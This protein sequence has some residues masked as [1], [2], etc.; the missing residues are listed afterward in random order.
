MCFDGFFFEIRKIKCYFAWLIN[1]SLIIRSMSVK[2]IRKALVFLIIML[3]VI[4]DLGCKKQARC[5]C[6]KDVLF[7]LQFEEAR[8][9]FNKEF[10]NV[11]VSTTANP[12]STYY[13]CNPGEMRKYFSESESGDVLLVSGKVYWNCNY[14]YNQSNYSYGYSYSSLYK[15][16]DIEVTSVSTNLYGK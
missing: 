3:P 2:S 5:G 9:Y 6:G 12:N 14:I 1:V 4:V 15:V 11:Q 10:T 8:E 16:Y 13:F 7:E